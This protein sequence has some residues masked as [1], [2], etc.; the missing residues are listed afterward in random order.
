M[1]LNLFKEKN[2]WSKS[3]ETVEEG[4][5]R[6]GEREREKRT[7]W[8][9][10]GLKKT[11]SVVARMK[12]Y[13]TGKC[14]FPPPTNFWETVVGDGGHVIFFWW[15]RVGS[16][17]FCCNVTIHFLP[18]HA[19]MMD[20]DCE[21]VIMFMQTPPFHFTRRCVSVGTYT[22]LIYYSY[23]AADNERWFRFSFW[24][25]SNAPLHRRFVEP[26]PITRRLSDYWTGGLN[27]EDNT[28]E[29]QKKETPKEKHTLTF[30]RY[31][32]THKI[33][34]NESVFWFILFRY[35]SNDAH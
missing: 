3:W 21:A 12:E 14:M 28:C 27:V 29:A 8:K 2:K 30:V 33:T 10:W 9:R 18:A 11:S 19:P 6:Q 16:W 20:G 17:S 34:L 35:C 22:F 31:T 25:V 32:H 26:F 1:W 15:N 13:C 23:V 5:T 7:I 24:P 4:R